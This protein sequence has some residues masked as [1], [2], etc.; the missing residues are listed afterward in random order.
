MTLGARLCHLLDRRETT[1]SL[2]ESTDTP[3]SVHTSLIPCPLQRMPRYVMLVN[4]IYLTH[5][6][7]QS[8]D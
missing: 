6:Q 1:A 7:T 3:A 4:N 5:E 8:G 2:K